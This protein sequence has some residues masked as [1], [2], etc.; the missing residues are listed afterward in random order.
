MNF[1]AARDSKSTN[2]NVYGEFQL[3]YRFR[4]TAGFQSHL[5]LAEDSVICLKI[6]PLFRS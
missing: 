1:L 5:T 4:E 3:F 2:F 6:R